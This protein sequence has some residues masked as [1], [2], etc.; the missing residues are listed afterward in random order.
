LTQRI[1]NPRLTRHRSRDQQL[2]HRRQVVGRVAEGDYGARVEVDD[3]REVGLLAGRRQLDGCRSISVGAPSG[4]AANVSGVVYLDAAALGSLL[5][6][7][8]RALAQA[9]VL[10]ELGHLVGLAHVNDSGAL[11]FPRA[12]G[13]VTAFGP[14]DR[15]GLAALGSGACQ[16]TI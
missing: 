10:H 1:V 13:E 8:D 11:M 14:G 16:P 4:M 6:A 15:A 2:R 12:S 7:G 9:V 3:P 5:A